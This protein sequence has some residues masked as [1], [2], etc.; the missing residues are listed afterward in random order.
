[1]EPI[2]D[3]SEALFKLTNQRDFKLEEV[4]ALNVAIKDIKDRYQFSFNELDQVKAEKEQLVLD[5]NQAAA[6]R[7]FHRVE[8]ENAKAEVERLK[9]V[10][11][12]SEI[13]PVL[14][15]NR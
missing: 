12:N 13:S 6:E 5:K 4:S 15:I 14:E 7:D 9:D 10:I 2:M 1:M 3:I 8:A 11:D